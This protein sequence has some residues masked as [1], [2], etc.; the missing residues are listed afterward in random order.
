MEPG[1]LAMVVGGSRGIGRAVC[2]N[3]ART[4]ES[5]GIFFHSNKT[6]A[7]ETAELV[8]G[9]GAEPLLIQ[10]DVRDQAEVGRRIEAAASDCGAL[11]VLIHTAGANVAWTPVRELDPK[12][13]TAFLDSDL[14]G[15]F[16]T[17]RA[18]LPIMHR[19]QHGSI[20]A[21]TSVAA[22]AAN[23]GSAQTAAAKAGVEAL[24]RVVAKEEGRHGIRANAV[25]V[26]LTDTDMGQEAVKHWGEKLTEKILAQ[27]AL[28][29][30][31]APEEVAAVVEFLASPAASY[32][33]GR[34]LAADGGQFLSA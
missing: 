16:N 15:V 4:H 5:I 28:P 11:D 20:V 12:D 8:R 3:L 27:S 26:G 24:I 1:K 2:V 34:V 19:Q 21:V 33:T 10:A 22:R 31:G 30:M 25:A 7:D 6:A 32:V 9:A 13:W 29:R 17:V 14:N 23:P 18:A